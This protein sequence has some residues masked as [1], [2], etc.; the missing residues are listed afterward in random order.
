M[1]I[2][3]HAHLDMNPFDE[4][5]AE[6]IERAVKG[7]V[8][9][10][11]TVGI[12]LDSS[13]SAL[14]LCRQ[15][16]SIY[17]S[18]GY[19]PHSAD[20]CTPEDLDKL[21]C[22]ALESKIVAWGEIG[23]D[24]YRRYSPPEKQLKIFLRQLEI[25]NDIHMPVIIHDRD[26]HMDVLGILKK[27]G[28][29]DRKGV[30]HCFSGDTDLALAL[31]ELGYFISIPGT[32]TYPKASEI[33]AVASTIPLGCMIVET[34]A[35]FLAPVP[36]RGKRNEP[37]F[38]TYTAKEIARLRNIDFEELARQTTENAGILFGWNTS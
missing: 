11:V 38:V 37:L 24:F 16:D 20:A 17:A 27:M 3:S 30:I 7:G 29:G 26:A 25:A 19:H 15:N 8:T 12:D 28:K 2:D 35:P 6:V 34:D 22:I 1:L 36:K 13:L 18:V 5:R 14:R 10:I 21:A 31:I 4:D 33:K 32:V 23:L 9:R